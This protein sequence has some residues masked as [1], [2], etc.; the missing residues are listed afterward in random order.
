MKPGGD[1]GRKP[2]AIACPLGCVVRPR[3]KFARLSFA[4]SFASALALRRIVDSMHQGAQ[5]SVKGL[6]N[7]NAVDCVAQF[8]VV[9]TCKRLSE[10]FLL[11]VQEA[12]LASI[13]F[14][15]LGFH[16]DN[17]SEYINY[18]VAD[19]LEKLRVEFTKSRPRRSTDSGLAE[20][21][22]GACLLMK[23]RSPS[24]MVE[25]M[26]PVGTTF[27]SAIAER[28]G[29]ITAAIS[30]TGCSHSHHRVLSILELIIVISKQ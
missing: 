3:R 15:I 30:A 24:T 21:K 19:L 23:I 8:E 26:D 18:T 17:G 28:N 1:T 4:S 29:S 13:P 20:T 14:Q 7:I 12:L 9:T 22:N 10:A 2:K 27:Q 16:A 5:D 11:P 25:F 6:Y